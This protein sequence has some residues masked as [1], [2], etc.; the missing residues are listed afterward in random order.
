LQR[1]LTQQLRFTAGIETRYRTSII[2]G[3][4][5][6]QHLAT[7]LLIGKRFHSAPAIRLADAR[8]LQIGHIARAD[9]R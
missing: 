8:L 1:Y 3:V 6:W 9:G 5:T 4:P 2:C 7:G